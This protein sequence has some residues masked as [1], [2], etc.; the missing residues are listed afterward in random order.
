MKIQRINNLILYLLKYNEYVTVDKISNDLSFS[1]RSIHNYLNS[2]YFNSMTK[3]AQLHKVPNKGIYL[4]AND[5]I[6]QE[7]ITRTKSDIT[8]NPAISDD[9]LKV[10]IRL[11]CVDERF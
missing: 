2:E 7:I 1:V 11:L 5:S 4:E 3:N 8:I 10:I 6:K 9:L